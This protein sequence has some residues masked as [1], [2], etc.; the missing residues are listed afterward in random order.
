MLPLEFNLMRPWSL[1]LFEEPWWKFY[2]S[3]VQPSI[4]P[5][6]YLCVLGKTT[7]TIT[8]SKDWAGELC[9]QVLVV[10]NAKHSL[11]VV[12]KIRLML[13]ALTVD[14]QQGRMTQN[15]V[16]LAFYKWVVVTRV[17]SFADRHRHEVASELQLFVIVS[18]LLAVVPTYSHLLVGTRSLCP[19][20]IVSPDLFV[21]LL[22]GHFSAQCSSKAEAN[23]G[24]ETSTCQNSSNGM[25]GQTKE[26]FDPVQFSFVVM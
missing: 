6:K 22:Q 8:Q 18:T 5:F 10:K 9:H 7:Q 4:D 1:W 19:L 15:V 12:L 11:A 3:I 25:F 2:S 23:G 21:P 14:L 17:N 16:G 24:A 13:K 20:Q 26:S